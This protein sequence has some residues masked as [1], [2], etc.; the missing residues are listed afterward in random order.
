MTNEELLQI[1]DANHLYL[2]FK[3]A[4]KGTDWKESVQRYEM[5]IL[6]NIFTSQRA[7]MAETYRPKPVVEFE[8]SERGHTRHI[9][10]LHIS[11][12]VIQRSLN[13]NV[14]VPRVTRK[15]IYDNGASQ[16][17]KG[18]DFA[19]RRFGFMLRKAYLEYGE[20]AVV[21]QID[22]TKYFDNI[23]HEIA[24]S[25]F[26]PMLNDAEYRLVSRLFE[27]FMVDVSY[28]SDEEYD[29][30]MSMVFNSLQYANIEKSLLTKE[31]FMAKSVGIGN[32]MSQITGVYY[33]HKIDNYCK[34]VKRIKYYCRFMDDTSMIFPSLE[35]AK[36]AYKEV[37]PICEKLGI[38]I[39]VKKT[40]F[41][42]ITDTITYLKINF[43]VLPNGRVIRKVHNSTILRRRRC[44]RKYKRLV[45]LGKLPLLDVI[46]WYKSWRG[47]Y[48]KYD[49]GL[50]IHRLDQYVKKLF[51]GNENG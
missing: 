20:N 50:K 27:D 15:L 1:C 16:K 31:K 26:K 49:S 43:R 28:M 36:Q 2:A 6:Q 23:V 7:I 19:I 32:Q 5:N 22:F 4:K 39:N 37:C 29:Q 18:T 42:K 10:S 8:I 14:L 34:I 38:F 48:R 47:S 30:C 51:G 41:R 35:Q 24:L 17:K 25:M 12:R 11:D 3:E 9:K 44:L 21:L 46:D 40:H 13:D 45:D 33:P